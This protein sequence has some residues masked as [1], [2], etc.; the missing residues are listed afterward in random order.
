[1]QRLLRWIAIPIHLFLWLGLLA[2]V[3]MMLHVTADVT[4]RFA[5]SRPIEGTTE[6]VAAY[7]MVAIAYLPW[8][9]IARHDRHIV[10]GIF[11]QIGS[12]RFD[13][14]LQI[15]VKTLTT[16]YVSVFVYRTQSGEVWLAGTKYLP[17]WPCRWMLPLAG[18]LMVLYLLLRIAS[19]IAAGPP[20]E[21]T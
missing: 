6:T 14:W 1:M 5:F 9:W 8:A 11:T 21:Q 18:G 3:L 17:V 16:V 10:A 12:P 13:F 2:G 20:R 15:A 7:Y 4:G 19:D